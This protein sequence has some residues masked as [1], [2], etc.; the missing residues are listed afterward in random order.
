MTDDEL[1]AIIRQAASENRSEYEAYAERLEKKIDTIAEGVL[2]VNERVD[3]LDAKV[4]QFQSQVAAEFEQVAIQFD[5]V[6]STI[7]LSHHELDGRLRALEDTDS[8][9]H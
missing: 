3:R 8:T 7:K 2:A 6:R 4:D 9:T 5:D 1:K